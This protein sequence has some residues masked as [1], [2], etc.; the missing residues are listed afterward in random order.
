M[1]NV[2]ELVICVLMLALVG[3]A[4]G[5]TLYVPGDFYPYSDRVVDLG[6]LL[7]RSWT[8]GGICRYRCLDT[9]GRVQ[10]D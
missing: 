10:F 2:K 8:P 1:R 5:Q 4:A 9:P 3:T 7:A 6:I